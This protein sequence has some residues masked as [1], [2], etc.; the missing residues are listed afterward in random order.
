MEKY[1]DCL[2][3]VSDCRDSAGGVARPPRIGFVID[4][5]VAVVDCEW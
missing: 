1:L 2:V 3:F 4:Y 5:E